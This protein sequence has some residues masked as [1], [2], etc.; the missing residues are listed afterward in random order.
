MLAAKRLE[1][2]SGTGLIGERI[3]PAYGHPVWQQ[4][5]CRLNEVTGIGVGVEFLTY[6]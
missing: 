2:V 3:H 6:V 5:L 1:Y 4:G